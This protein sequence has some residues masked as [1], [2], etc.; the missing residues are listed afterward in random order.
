MNEPVPYQIADILPETS[1][2]QS[3]AFFTE[4][5]S[6]WEQ[7]EEALRVLQIGDDG[8][9]GCQGIIYGGCQGIIY[10]PEWRGARV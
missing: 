4:T 2:W 5:Q 8:G 6:Q 1:I 3:R 7:L 9:G 10:V